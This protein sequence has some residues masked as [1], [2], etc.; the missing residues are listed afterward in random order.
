MLTHGTDGKHKAKVRSVL[1]SGGY[2]LKRGGRAYSEAHEDQKQDPK[3]LESSVQEHE[4]NMNHGRN[5]SNLKTLKSGGI[6]SAEKSV[7]RADKTS[8]KASKG[9]KQAH[10]KINIAV[11]PHP[12]SGAGAV[13]PPPL[14]AVSPMGGMAPHPP[15]APG[16]MP[17][18]GRPGMS[19]QVVKRGGKIFGKKIGHYEAGAGSGEGRLEK[20]KNYKKNIKKD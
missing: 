15:M 7:H 2:K 18:M 12:S 20:E 14:P 4:S 5:Y 10:T 3:L 17:P 19:P 13:N 8:R 1:R 6:A 11:M 9:G 16:V